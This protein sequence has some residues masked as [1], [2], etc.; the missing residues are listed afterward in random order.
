MRIHPQDIGAIYAAY[1]DSEIGP[2]AQSA[3][4]K[5]WAYSSAYVVDKKA[6][7]YLSNEDRVKQL[8]AMGIMTPDGMIDMD[9]LKEMCSHAIDKSGGQIEAMGLILDKTDVDKVYNIGR[10]F[11]R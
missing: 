1:V 7:E 3:L 2:K 8:T 4:Q 6:K 11:A 10:S 9:F 5:F